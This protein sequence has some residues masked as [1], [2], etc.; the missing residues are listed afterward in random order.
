MLFQ[1]FRERSSTSVLTENA[2]TWIS[3]AIINKNN[4]NHRSD[5]HGK[6]QLRTVLI[7]TRTNPIAFSLCYGSGATLNAHGKLSEQIGSQLTHLPSLM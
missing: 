3:S 6:M 2:D 4:D 5:G 7:K 1:C